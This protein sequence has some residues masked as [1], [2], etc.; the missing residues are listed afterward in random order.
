MLAAMGYEVVHVAGWWC[1]IDPYRSMLAA[2]AS[3]GLLSVAHT[4]VTGA[5]FSTIA[6]YRCGFCDEPMVRWDVD[7]IESMVD[8]DHRLSVHRSCYRKETDRGQ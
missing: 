1:R 2:L 7:W 4:D 8:G 3:V 6:D 5:E